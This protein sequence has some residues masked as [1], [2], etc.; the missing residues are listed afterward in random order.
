LYDWVLPEGRRH[1]PQILKITYVQQTK[2]V[3]RQPIGGSTRMK[4]KSQEASWRKRGRRGEQK[5]K[6]QR[7]EGR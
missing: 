4:V 5:I 3:K 1:T 2:T 6:I 7:E